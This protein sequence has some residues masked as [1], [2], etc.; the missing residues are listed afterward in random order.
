MIQTAQSKHEGAPPKISLI[1][2]NL[3]RADILR[4]CLGSV[5]AQT[6][7]PL[8]VVIMDAGSTDGSLE[9]IHKAMEAMRAAGM[10]TLLDLCEPTGVATS[11]NRGA[12]LASGDLLAFLDNDAILA[13]GALEKAARRFAADSRLGVLSFRV[14]LRD[15]NLPDPYSWIYRRPAASWNERE[16]ETFTFTGG[17]CCIRTEAF[18]EA[19]GFW[20]ILKYS[21]E[22]EDLCLRLVDRGWKIFYSPDS[23]M[24]HFPG[25][26]SLEKLILRRF[27][28]L[29]NGLLVL[30]RRL[31]LPM[32]L[33]FCLLRVLSMTLR[34]LV[35][36]RGSLPQ[37]LKAIPAAFSLWRQS[38]V[39]RTPIAWSSAMR[40]LELHFHGQSK[41]FSD[42]D[43][44]SRV[45]ILGCPFDA[46]S[47]GMAVERVKR[48]ILTDEHLHIVTGN[49]DFVMKARKDDA[50]AEAICGAGL[51]VADG[52][53]ILWAAR[54]LGTPLPGRVNGTELAWECAR[55]AAETGCGLALVGA[56]EGVAERAAERIAKRYKGR[57]TPVNTPY[58][59]TEEGCRAVVERIKASGAGIVLAALGAPKQEYFLRDNLAASGANVGI[60]I[61]SAFDIIAMETPRAPRWM[62][63]SGLEWLY[64]LYREPR[65]LWKR[66]LID[67]MPFFWHLFVEW[68]R[69]KIS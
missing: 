17:A 45:D 13:S 28:E 50:F 59:L 61:G 66:Y 21:R 51:V 67:D 32:A 1:I 69:R 3:N 40:F 37:L 4:V 2:H 24:R 8:E 53:P 33:A 52:V 56:A 26:M 41:L 62:R 60:G 47:F 65:R 22:E 31:P 64:R 43:V 9:I 25:P 11:R 44:G 5:L 63:G 38:G 39:K 10:E 58:P 14:L 68:L 12:S 15:S 7:R 18:R 29:Q 6:H 36:E 57:L 54:F 16:F 23:L 19:G 30:W 27:F 46:I 34:M 42:A 55:L 49:V 48:A 35:K 20:E